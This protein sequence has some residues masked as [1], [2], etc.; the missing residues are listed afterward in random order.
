MTKK[1]INV[2]EENFKKTLVSISQ[3]GITSKDELMSY[4]NSEEYANLW[5]SVQNF[6]SHNKKTSYRNYTTESNY[7][8]LFLKKFVNIC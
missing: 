7:Y 6:I 3:K 1:T 4:E 8:L 2:Y 5:F